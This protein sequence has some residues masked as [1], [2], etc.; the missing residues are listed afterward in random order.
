MK[1]LPRL[2]IRLTKKQRKEIRRVF[3]D[4]LYDEF[5]LDNAGFIIAE[6]MLKTG[7]LHVAYIPRK[8]GLKIAKE[9]HTKPVIEINDCL[10]KEVK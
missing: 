10:L 3:Y 6:P 4:H 1:H 7:I 9:L 5:L 2:E 8:Q